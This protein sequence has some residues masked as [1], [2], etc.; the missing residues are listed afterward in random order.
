MNTNT[1]A[2]NRQY[3]DT[4]FR[5]LFGA[6]ERKSY[7]LSLYNALTGSSYTDTAV[8]QLT[9]LADALYMNVK[10]D[11]SILVDSRMVL[12]EHQSTRNPNM[13]LRG[14]V[15]L[16]QL[17]QSYTVEHKLNLYGHKRLTLPTPYYCVFYNGAEEVADRTVLRLSDS[18]TEKEPPHGLLPAVEVTAVVYNINKGH[19]SRLMCACQTLADY[20]YF[21]SLIRSYNVHMPLAEAIDAAMQQCIDEGVLADYLSSK[22]AEVKSMLIT[23]FD[24]AEY[25]QIVEREKREIAEAARAEGEAIGEANGRAKERRD[26]VA[27]LVGSGK[28]TREEAAELLG[29]SVAE[30]DQALAEPEQ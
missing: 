13:P 3:K 1:T 2:A 17:Y 5:D 16:S 9:T 19:N 22:R 24:Q 27:T 18:F 15:Y 4:V 6:E 11:V 7:A 20:A 23:E 25:E 14:L 30:V 28:L 29:V 12:W 21:M 10:N 8:L 26:I